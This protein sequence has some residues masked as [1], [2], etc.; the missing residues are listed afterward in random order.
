MTVSEGMFGSPM[1]VSHPRWAT[2]LLS[3]HALVVVDWVSVPIPAQ[4][5]TEA[6]SWFPLHRKGTALFRYRRSF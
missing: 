3:I 2:L 4:Q 6:V 1:S 5:K